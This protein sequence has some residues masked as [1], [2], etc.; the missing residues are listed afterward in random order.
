MKYSF[1][2]AVNNQAR[3]VSLDHVEILIGSTSCDEG[4]HIEALF[5]F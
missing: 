2:G 5:R 3:S 4:L 1:S